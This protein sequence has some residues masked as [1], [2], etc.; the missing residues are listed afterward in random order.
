MILGADVWIGLSDLQTEGT[1]VWVD[2]T[3]VSKMWVDDRSEWMIDVGDVSGWMVV[4]RGWCEWV[5]DNQT[6]L[7]VNRWIDNGWMVVRHVW[8]VDER[9]V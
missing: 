7:A 9:H 2:G 3:P 6:W 4:R 1:W 8:T 5:D